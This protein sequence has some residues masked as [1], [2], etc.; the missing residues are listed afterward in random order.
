M[1][2]PAGPVALAGLGIGAG[3]GA[4][5][6][7]AQGLP[8]GSQA[9]LNLIA[10][11]AGR[12]GSLGALAGPKGALTGLGVGAGAGAM[13]CAIRGLPANSPECIALIAGYGVVGGAMLAPAGPVALA[14][15]GLGAGV[16]AMACAKRGLPAGSAECLG[17]IAG[18]AVQTGGLAGI[19]GPTSLAVGLGLSPGSSLETKIKSSVLAIV[20]DHINSLGEVIP[21]KAIRP[22]LVKCGFGDDVLYAEKVWDCEHYGG[23]VI[24]INAESDG[25]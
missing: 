9:C 13:D 5:Q 21:P 25:S 16:G 15:L 10:S 17:L 7:A 8:A 12:G 3:V 1:L 24:P 19:M 20:Q 6:C 14:G 4:A 11:G 23:V 18:G 22:G 2:A